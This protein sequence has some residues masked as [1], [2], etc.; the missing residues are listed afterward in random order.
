MTLLDLYN[1]VLRLV[2]IVPNAKR[3]TRHSAQE[4]LEARTMLTTA[5]ADNYYANSSAATTIPAAQGVL[6]NDTGSGLT[7]VLV[8][9]PYFGYVTFNS[10]GSFTY[11]NTSSSPGDQ[12]TYKDWDGTSYSNTVAVS[13]TLSSNGA[14]PEA[15]DDNAG[16]FTHDRTLNVSAP[17]VLSNDGDPNYLPLTSVLDTGPCQTPRPTHTGMAENF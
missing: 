12:I 11:T 4:A 16:S 7:A 17:G 2:S 1:N 8:S 6:A 10:D 9:N 3:R 13:L 14:A 15:T 5:V